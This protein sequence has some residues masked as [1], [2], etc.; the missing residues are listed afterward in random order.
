MIPN[1]VSICAS[2]LPSLP[3]RCNN[4]PVIPTLLLLVGVAPAGRTLSLLLGGSLLRYDAAIAASVIVM[5]DEEEEGAVRTP[6]L[7]S[8]V[9]D[10]ATGG[11]G[12]VF[13]MDIM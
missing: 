3:N 5:D 13:I 12:D 2:P 11:G 1:G 9:D 7:V 6:A 8:V 4:R 10:D